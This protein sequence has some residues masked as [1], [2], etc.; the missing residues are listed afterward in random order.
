M[1][2][3]INPL[4]VSVGKI[5]ASIL[6]LFL[7]SGCSLVLMEDLR[8]SSFM[9]KKQHYE[10]IKELQPRIDSHKTVTSFQ[11]YLL[12]GAYYEIR[13]YEKM[14]TTV[15]LMD[16]QLGING[17]AYFFGDL[18]PCP[19]ILRGYAF[20][21][22]GEYAKAL[23]EAEKA[24]AIV[25][26]PT[27]KKNSF[28]AS[29]MI[30][31]AG[32]AG[33]SCA[34]QGEDSKMDYYL[35]LLRNTATQDTILGPEKYTAIAR[36]YMA[37]KNYK[38]ALEAIKNPAANTFG[39]AG[40]FY[41]HT[42]EEIPKFFILSKC[43]Y[44]TGMIKE[45]KDGYD[46]LL[47]HPQIRQIGGIYWPVLL[48]QA[49]IAA[50]EGQIVPAVQLL[51]QAVE[52]IEQQRA[53]IHTETGRIGYLGDKQEV[54]QD[55]VSLLVASGKIEEA[56]QYAERAK[57]RALVDLLASQKGI[58]VD[59][60][61]NALA[62]NTL[63]L[64]SESEKSMNVI[65]DPTHN[66]ASKETR[67]VTLRL[68]D[69]LVSQAPEFAS[70]V[71]VTGLS[72][73]EIQGLLSNDEALLEY[74]AAGD[75]WYAFVVTKGEIA[76]RKLRFK[77]IEKDIRNLRK[78]LTH[79]DSQSWSALSRSLYDKIFAP[80][81]GLI[82]A[83]KILIVPHGVL[84]YMPFNALA[85]DKDC[86]VDH[87]TIRILPSAAVL[88]YL[89][90]KEKQPG[91]KTL[92]MGNPDLGDCRYD[93]AFAED[94]ARAIAD[95]MPGSTVLVK[96]SATTSFLIKNG[97]QYNRIHIA[98]HGLFDPDDPLHSALLLAKDSENDSYLTAGDLYGLSLNADLI[99]L[100]ACETALGKVLKGD[101]VIGFTRGFLYAGARSIVSSLWMVDDR[102]TRD[103]MIDFYK[104]L[105][106]MDK[107]EALRQA[108]L[109]I[110][111]RYPHPHYWAAFQLTGM[112]Q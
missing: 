5:L 81:S 68:R 6:L 40:A 83:K 56:F 90:Q 64:L 7:F 79:S 59:F 37:K 11:L 73:R 34:I 8:I 24:R 98:A 106:D 49:K 47:H 43:L 72:V 31:I 105:T 57:G 36:I 104:N 18:R 69:E 16:K 45:A 46:Q 10:V 91:L 75:G 100:S 42:F 84:H 17:R 94:E 32:I 27:D 109:D 74:Y 107:D 97:S 61:K 26:Q 55:L 38:A 21:D 77:D 82:T 85:S 101:D 3:R 1:I 58:H 41:D 86:L 112:S 108:Q 87:F 12:A 2:T 71:T 93:L 33:V 19:A 88:S 25:N 20:L 103:L 95:I 99:T 110:K 23:K 14:R 65:T 89:A 51:K 102:A 52:V 44:E 50:S 13:D 53:S 76:V 62:G 15:D 30:D 9:Q 70:L 66:R 111:K 63:E 39:L 60:T 35:N 48:D 96:G 29:Q 80:V 67:S 22:Q 54:Y 28:Y 78:A 4:G 92:I